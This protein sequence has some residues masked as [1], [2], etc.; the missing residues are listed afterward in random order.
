MPSSGIIDQ[1]A[2]VSGDSITGRVNIEFPPFEKGR[3]F[4]ITRDRSRQSEF[5]VFD[6]NNLEEPLYTISLPHTTTGK[7]MTWASEKPLFFD[8]PDIYMIAFFQAND[9][10]DP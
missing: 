9:G 8:N 7:Y 4:I 1:V 3:F 10:L 6:K 2:S 5:D